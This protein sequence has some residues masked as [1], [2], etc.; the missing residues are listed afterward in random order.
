MVLELFP[1]CIHDDECRRPTIG[2]PRGGQVT[3]KLEKEPPGPPCLGETL[4]RVSITKIAIFHTIHIGRSRFKKSSLQ[5]EAVFQLL[6][7]NRYAPLGT[8]ISNRAPDPGS[9]VSTI[10]ISVIPRISEARKSP[11]PV[12]W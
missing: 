6:C 11:Y 12:F 4:R 5:D 9:P 8:R 7:V 2:R 3:K 10:G 1:L